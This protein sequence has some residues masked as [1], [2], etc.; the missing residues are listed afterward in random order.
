MNLLKQIRSVFHFVVPFQSKEVTKNWSLQSS[1][2]KKTI[3]SIENQKSKNYKI[4]LVCHDKPK[5]FSGSKN[6]NVVRVKFDIPRDKQEMMLDKRRKI[7]KGISIAEKKTGD[8]FMVMDAD[9]RVSNRLVNISERIGGKVQMVRKGYVW[10]YNSSFVFKW[11]M[12]SKPIFRY[13][14]DNLPKSPSDNNE[15]MILKPHNKVGVLAEKGLIDAN[16]IPIHSYLYIVDTQDNHSGASF[17][18]FIN[19]KN[20]LNRFL[21]VRVMTNSIKKEFYVV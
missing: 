9:D 6:V 3:E 1:L 21:G 11:K 20:V 12:L 8:R 15:Y 7:K 17:K 4:H 16:E 13:D 18:N 10:P 2:C 19:K 5:N 14:G